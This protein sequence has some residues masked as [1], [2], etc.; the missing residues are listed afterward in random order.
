ML[1][2]KQMETNTTVKYLGITAT[3]DEITQQG[4]KPGIQSAVRKVGMM[5][6]AEMHESNMI[7]E[8]LLRLSDLMGLPAAT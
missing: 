5:A 3:Y 4:I 1:A 2:G 8:K 7:S 6:A